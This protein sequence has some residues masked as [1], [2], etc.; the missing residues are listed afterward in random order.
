M[1][2]AIAVPHPN[3]SYRTIG[4]ETFPAPQ[5]LYATGVTVGEPQG[6]ADILD[7]RAAA[8]KL[9]AGPH[10]T[11]ALLEQQSKFFLQPVETNPNHAP[12]L[13]GATVQEPY[14]LEGRVGREP[15]KIDLTDPFV[16]SLIDGPVALSKYTRG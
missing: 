2:S 11:V 5:A 10:G 4:R 6:Y 15:V 12:G 16:L 1:I 9:T 13:I 14:V 7:A 3:F 8:E